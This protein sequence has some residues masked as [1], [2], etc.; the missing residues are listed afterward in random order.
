[1]CI[2]NILSEA[3]LS[4]LGPARRRG[5]HSGDG[6]GGVDPAGAEGTA[7][8]AGGAEGAAGG[9]EGAAG[10][11]EAV[12]GGAEGA[13][14]AE[15]EDAGQQDLIG[16]AAGVM[17]GQAPSG[18]VLESTTITTI[19]NARAHVVEQVLGA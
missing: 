19:S 17:Y 15:N 18:H 11:A 1:M 5:G 4:W 3:V 16:A 7:V 10:Y 12:A 9:A 8:S 14:E 13:G 2:H 6:W